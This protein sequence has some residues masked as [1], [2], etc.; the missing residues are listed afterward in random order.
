MLRKIRKFV[1]MVRNRKNYRSDPLRLRRTT[2][3]KSSLLFVIACDQDR[4]DEDYIPVVSRTWRY[5]ETI[6]N[7][8]VC[9]IN[10][11]PGCLYRQKANTL[12]LKPCHKRV[13]P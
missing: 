11:R 5:L 12:N 3:S 9:P 7:F 2:R 13:L 8:Q 1:Y 6:V 10:H 4:N